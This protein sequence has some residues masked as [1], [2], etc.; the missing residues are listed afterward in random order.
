MKYLFGFVAICLVAGGC[1]SSRVDSD[2]EGR[3]AR[4]M[5]L[6][7][8]LEQAYVLDQATL[9][10]QIVAELYPASSAYPSA[11]RKASLLYL[12]PDNPIRND[13]LALRWV[14]IYLGLPS[15]LPDREDARTEHLLLER[16]V[17]LEQRFTHRRHAAD[18]LTAIIRRQDTQLLNQAQQLQSLQ[19]E[20][21]QVRQELDKL[22]Q[23]DVQINRSRRK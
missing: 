1:V 9:E 21:R 12:N 4:H 6:G 18:S 10:Y 2:T 17:A 23:V 13:S 22:K 3:A 5:A 20:L 19:N 7:D 15:Q 11:V 8:S 14:S 16:I